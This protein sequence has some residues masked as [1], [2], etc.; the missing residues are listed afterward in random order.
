LKEQREA[1]R[2]TIAVAQAKLRRLNV[3]LGAVPSLG[4]DSPAGRTDKSAA[5]VSES[6]PSGSSK[7]KRE[8]A[9]ARL[10]DS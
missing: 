7:E 3:G 6:S 5:L 8:A 10:A 9:R 4:D 2:A 1:A